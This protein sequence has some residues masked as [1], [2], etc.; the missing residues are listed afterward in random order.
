VRA[1]ALDRAGNL[2]DDFAVIEADGVVHCLNA[3]SPAATACLAIGADLAER[4]CR[5]LDGT[6]DP[7]PADALQLRG[8]RA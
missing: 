6:C 4:V 1:Q 5:T 7:S 3:P 8:V 2:V